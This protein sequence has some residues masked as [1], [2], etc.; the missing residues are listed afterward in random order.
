MRTRIM[1]KFNAERPGGKDKCGILSGQ[2]VTMSFPDCNS[3]SKADNVT[4]LLQHSRSSL[5]WGLH[6]WHCNKIII[7][8][9]H[10]EHRRKCK[11]ECTCQKK[12]EI[13]T[14]SNWMNDATDA[15]KKEWWQW[16]ARGIGCSGM[17][18]HWVIGIG[19]KRNWMQWN[20]MSLSYW[21]WM[22]WIW[23]QWIAYNGMQC[24]WVIGI[25]VSGCRGI[26]CSTMQCFEIQITFVDV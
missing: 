19:C 22:Q 2:S 15:L 18:C 26:G 14:I 12:S 7:M 23:M 24:H 16:N 4:P 1:P 6:T 5:S 21:N 17:Q 8:A 3:V 13:Q 25:G 9:L 10:N 20:A 11:S